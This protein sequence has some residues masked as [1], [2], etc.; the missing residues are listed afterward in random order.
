[1]LLPPLCPT[2][3][4]AL[5]HHPTQ[6]VGFLVTCGGVGRQDL[7]TTLQVRGVSGGARV[8]PSR[9]LLGEAASVGGSVDELSSMSTRP[10]TAWTPAGVRVQA[11]ELS[12]KSAWG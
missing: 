2:V 3:L 10:V 5:S 4:S 11:D 9:A 8:L 7:L 12:S 6:K 1:M